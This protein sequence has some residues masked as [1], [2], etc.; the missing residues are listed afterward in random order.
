MSAQAGEVCADFFERKGTLR[1]LRSLKSLKTLR[2]VGDGGHNGARAG[3]LSVLSNII[4]GFK[5]V[6]DVKV[7]G[8]RR[9]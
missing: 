9:T 1:S 7:C 3:K 8:Q 5:V 6:N 2:L 4:N